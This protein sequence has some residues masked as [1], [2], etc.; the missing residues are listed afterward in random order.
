[1]IKVPM[2]YGVSTSNKNR[3]FFSTKKIWV[4]EECCDDMMDGTVRAL[5]VRLGFSED[6]EG[7]WIYP[8]C[9]YEELI[10]L[11]NNLK[12][13]GFEYDPDFENFMNDFEEEVEEEFGTDSEED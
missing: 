11:K 1:M 3:F 8:Y 10:V 13:L 6:Q 5:L 9:E 2:V 12:S 4:E 7:V